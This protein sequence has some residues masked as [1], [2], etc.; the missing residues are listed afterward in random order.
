MNVFYKQFY[1]KTLLINNFIKINSKIY[2]KK[3]IKNGF[4]FKGW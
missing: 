4:W 3:V 2:I 1:D